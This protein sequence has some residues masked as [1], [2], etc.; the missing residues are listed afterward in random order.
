M[1]ILNGKNAIITASNRG[2]GNAVLVDFA[3]NG[4][5]I[6]ACSRKK[7]VE[8]EN[9]LKDLSKAHNVDIKPIY[10]DVTDSEQM[11]EAYKTIRAEKKNVD[12]LVNCAGVFN[13]DFFQ[14]TR[15]DTVKEVFAVNVFAA[16]ELTQYVLKSMIRQKS[17]SI[18]NISSVSGLDAKPGNCTYGSSKSAL[19]SF[20]KS[21]AAEIGPLGIRANS[22]APGPTFTDMMKK[23][24]DKIGDKVLNS[25]A[26]NRWAEVEEIAAAVTFLASDRSSFINGQVIRVDGGSK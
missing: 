23:I 8:F 24:Y 19:I 20:T 7:S 5:N 15:M 12:V 26:M 9:Q 18:I 25:C 13:V 4:A 11:K 10:F 22:I 16:M 6:W 14:M 17:G 2:I 1:K 21:L 3:I